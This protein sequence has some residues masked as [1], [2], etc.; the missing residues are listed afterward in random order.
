MS[1]ARFDLSN[2][3]GLDARTPQAFPHDFEVQHGGASPLIGI[4]FYGPLIS[5]VLWSLLLWVGW[6]IF[7]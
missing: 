4:L 2:R 6:Q 3:R 5:A 1:D 7:S